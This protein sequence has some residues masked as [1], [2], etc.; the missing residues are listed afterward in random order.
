MACIGNSCA[1]GEEGQNG[2]LGPFP[3][4]GSEWAA[5]SIPKFQNSLLANQQLQNLSDGP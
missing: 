2:R 1:S 4:G 3:N 5:S